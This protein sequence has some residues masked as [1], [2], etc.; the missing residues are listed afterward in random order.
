MTKL[1]ID[2][3]EF[4][5]PTVGPGDLRIQNAVDVSGTARLVFWHAT[6]RR[7]PLDSLTLPCFVDE[8]SLAA[9]I[10]LMI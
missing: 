5:N 4:F 6:G 2:V 8:L 10:L 7:A 1:A 3:V 9:V